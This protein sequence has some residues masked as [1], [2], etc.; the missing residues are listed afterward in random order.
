[1]KIERYLFYKQSDLVKSPE[2]CMYIVHP[3]KIEIP[4]ENMSAMSCVSCL[5]LYKFIGL[6]NFVTLTP[7]H[8][9]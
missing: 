9:K 6:F 1:M 4:P 8:R 5:G 7:L 2:H 3:A